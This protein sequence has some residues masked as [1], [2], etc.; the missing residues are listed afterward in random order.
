MAFNLKDLVGDHEEPT[1]SHS[2]KSC[3]AVPSLPSATYELWN[4]WLKFIK[5]G[6]F[7]EYVSSKE[8]F[9]EQE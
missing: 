6:K 2:H 4:R 3:C 7:E 8:A 1:A 9:E 5:Y